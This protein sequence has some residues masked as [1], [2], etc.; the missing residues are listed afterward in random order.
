[1]SQSIFLSFIILSLAY[2]YNRYRYLLFEKFLFL[3]EYVATFILN[4][5]IAKFLFGLTMKLTWSRNLAKV[6]VNPKTSFMVLEFTLSYNISISLCLHRI[7]N[8]RLVNILYIIS[9]NY[10]NDL[11]QFTIITLIK[12]QLII[13]RIII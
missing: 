9:S 8:N 7:I 4:T 13:K 2:T 6:M 11:I 10:I 3:L 5:A 1:M 12:I